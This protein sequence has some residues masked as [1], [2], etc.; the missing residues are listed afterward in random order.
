[1][2]ARLASRYK[3]D[4]RVHEVSEQSPEALKRMLERLSECVE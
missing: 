4:V 2:V 1:V 3:A